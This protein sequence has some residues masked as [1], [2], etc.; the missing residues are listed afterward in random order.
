MP[1][2][3][4]SNQF[5][6]DDGKVIAVPPTLLITALGIVPDV[7]RCRSMDAKAAG[8][9]LLLVGETSSEMGGSHYASLGDLAGHLFLLGIGF[10]ALSVLMVSRLRQSKISFAVSLFVAVLSISTATGMGYKY[11]TNGFETREYRSQLKN[12]SHTVAD[13]PTATLSE[14]SIDLQHSGNRISVEANLKLTN[15][16]QSVLDSLLLTLNPGLIV[17]RIMGNGNNLS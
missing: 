6:T 17:N 9:V 2:D 4:L 1:K 5:T 13:Y 16:N 15:D 14:C 3:S 10:T 7:R 11:L 8:D 12:L